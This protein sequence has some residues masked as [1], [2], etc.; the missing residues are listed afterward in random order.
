MN[1]ILIASNNS[2]KI[3]E[4]K[5]IFASLPFKLLTPNDINLSSDFDPQET[6]ST[7]LEN[8][9][10]KAQAF[11]IKTNLR[12]LADDSG[13]IVDALDGRP[14]VYSK[15]YGTNDKDRID[16]LLL[17]LKNVSEELRTARFESAVCVF[18][19]EN[20]IFTCTSET[21]EG[22]I[23]KTPK[24]TNGFGYDP[25]FIPK[26]ID[27]NLTFAQIK[28]E[29]KNKISHRARALEKLVKLLND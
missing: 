4:I 8:A 5:H 28:S 15:R 3:E 7:F 21:V 23:S 17:E 11:G 6:G 9:Q 25:I 1:K 20:N 16:K 10:I 24:G 26:E 13:L 14:G 27:G 2:G 18:D 19:P 12:S 29:V 22:K